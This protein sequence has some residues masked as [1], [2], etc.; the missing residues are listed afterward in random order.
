MIY[1]SPDRGVK[2]RVLRECAT[3]RLPFHR[4][5]IYVSPP[6]ELRFAV[7]R[8]GYPESVPTTLTDDFDP[9]VVQQIQGRLD[10]VEA[11]HGV[12]V[13]W[14][15]ESGS[16]AWGFPSPDSDYDCRFLHV[17]PIEDYLSPWRPR[18]V[19]ETP[20][21]EVL[22]VNGWDLVKA[23]RLATTSNATVAEWLQS[24][25]VYRGDTDFAAELLQLCREVVH[26]DAVSRHY[27]HVGRSHWNRSGAAEGNT[28]QLK[29]LFYS[30]RPAAALHWMRTHSSPVPPMHLPTLLAEAPPATEVIDAITELIQAKAVTRELGDGVVPAPI[31]RFIMHEFS[32]AEDAQRT[33]S[34]R[35]HAAATSTFIDLVRRF[36]PS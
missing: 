6:L 2:P 26:P 18:D 12:A 27:Y 21:D 15:V 33:P 1:Q 10:E 5:K 30:I 34:P 31:R 4:R 35:D 14:A 22:D 11:E 29:K 17:R 16:R 23:V 25:Y 7:A 32:L 3:L 28:I 36:A 9:T 24:P 8:T 19:I 20:L 13:L